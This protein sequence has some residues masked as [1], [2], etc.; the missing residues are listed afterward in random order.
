MILNSL[1]RGPKKIFFQKLCFIDIRGHIGLTLN[2]QPEYL[3]SLYE[4]NVITW[5][6]SQRTSIEYMETYHP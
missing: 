6:E 2:E 1:N 4:T 3:K 5:P